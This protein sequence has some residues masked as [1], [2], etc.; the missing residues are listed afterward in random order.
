MVHSLILQEATRQRGIEIELQTRE[1]RQDPMESQ[2][3]EKRINIAD[4]RSGSHRVRT[5]G[6]CGK[7]H[8]DPC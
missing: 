5:C 3:M 6:K 1:Y 8:E 2:P 4:V 7:Y